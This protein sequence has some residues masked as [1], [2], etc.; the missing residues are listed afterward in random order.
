MSASSDMQQCEIPCGVIK[1]T[2]GQFD[3]FWRL[4]KTTLPLSNKVMAAG[5]ALDDEGFSFNLSRT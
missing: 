2:S 4:C 1:L 3:E 5:K